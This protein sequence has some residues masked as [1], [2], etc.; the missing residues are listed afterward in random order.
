MEASVTESHTNYRGTLVSSREIIRTNQLD[1][2]GVLPWKLF[3]DT[4]AFVTHDLMSKVG[5]DTKIT[6]VIDKLS[7]DHPEAPG[8]MVHAKTRREK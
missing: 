2:L 7:E 5:Y 6:I 3:A 8:Y 4:V 1:Q